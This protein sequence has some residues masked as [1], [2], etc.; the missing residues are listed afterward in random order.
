[1][2]TRRST[3]TRTAARTVAAVL[4][5]DAAIHLYWTTGLTW[6]APD[7]A[8]LSH[9]VLNADVPF[10]PRVLLP[11]ATVLLCAATLLLT[12]TGHLPALARRLPAPLL[13]LAPYAV[14]TG[15]LLRAL[16]GLVWIT[17]LG[18][19]PAD[20]FYWLNLALYTPLCLLCAAATWTVA[21]SRT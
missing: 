19:S 8:T 17:G 5:A 14:A 7:R 18:S 2:D 10:T 6:P 11:L 15:L 20:P 16:A 1:M 13:H 12:R 9:L 3:R 4:A 21:R